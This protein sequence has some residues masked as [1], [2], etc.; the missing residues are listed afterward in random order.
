M[1]ISVWCEVLQEK[2]L[3]IT[4]LQQ[5]LENFQ[6]KTD[7]AGVNKTSLY[8]NKRRPRGGPPKTQ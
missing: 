7:I 1:I 2:K 5:E 6:H 3:E 4:H 8:M